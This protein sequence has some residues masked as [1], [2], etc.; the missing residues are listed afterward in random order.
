MQFRRRS[1]RAMTLRAQHTSL[2]P[3]GSAAPA[4]PNRESPYFAAAA[5]TKPIY[6]YLGPFRCLLGGGSPKPIVIHLVGAVLVVGQRVLTVSSSTMQQS[7]F[8]GSRQ[9][10]SDPLKRREADKRSLEHALE[11]Y[12]AGH[13]IGSHLRGAIR[14]AVEDGTA[15]EIQ[16]VQHS[17][18][19]SGY[20]KSN[21]VP[22]HKFVASVVLIKL[23]SDI[24]WTTP[25][26]GG[27]RRAPTRRA[28]AARIDNV[29]V[30]DFRKCYL[31]PTR[32]VSLFSCV[33]TC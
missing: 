20:G 30:S 7:L 18:S 23:Q 32:R 24:D 8:F 17:R 21:S 3:R 5:C 14:D 15:F 2:R 9:A 31:H 29:Y 11:P 33:R 10:A 12:F 22:G 27:P 16:W 4:P 19:A 25:T 1:L 13:A 6:F 28:P 26:S